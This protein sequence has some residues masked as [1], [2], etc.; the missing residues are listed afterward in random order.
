M[1]IDKVVARH[2]E[3]GWWRVAG[4]SIA[5]GFLSQCPFSVLCTIRLASGG[6][7]PPVPSILNKP[8]PHQI[9]NITSVLDWIYYYIYRAQSL[10]W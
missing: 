7:V 10:P 9:P 8:S 2:T 6:L 3:I 1:A 5:L 4:D